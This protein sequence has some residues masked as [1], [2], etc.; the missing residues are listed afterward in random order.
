MGAIATF[1]YPTWAARFPEFASVTSTQAAAFFTEACCFCRNDGAGPVNDPNTQTTL[2]N[3]LTAHIA[4]LAVGTG[5][6]QAPQAL[7]GR[8]SSA[9][10]GS[11]SVSTDIGALPGTEAWFAQSTYGFNY[12]QLSRPY[13]SFRYVSRRGGRC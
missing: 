4:F 5:A 13:R 1:S 7:I 9:S 2:L 6:T 12:W 8:I 11:V 10:Q 3:Y